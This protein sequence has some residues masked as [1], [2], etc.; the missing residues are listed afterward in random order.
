MTD[1]LDVD[2]PLLDAIA[3]QLTQAGDNVDR[4]GVSAPPPPDAG[5]GTAVIADVLARLCGGAA[6]LSGT[7][8]A[9][10]SRVADASQRYAQEDAAGGQSIHGAY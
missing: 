3:E 5:P 6:E 10:G 2:V 7:L 8:R 4:S 1:R 9:A